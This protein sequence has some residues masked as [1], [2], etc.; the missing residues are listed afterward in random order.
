MALSMKYRSRTL[1][2]ANTM[3]ATSA[4]VLEKVILCVLETHSTAPVYDE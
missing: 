1:L 2:R 3:D 4:S